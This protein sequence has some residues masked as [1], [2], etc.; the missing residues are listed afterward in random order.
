MVALAERAIAYTKPYTADF[1]NS[2]VVLKEASDDLW[3]AFETR[4]L[5]PPPRHLLPVARGPARARAHQ[6]AEC[7]RVHGV[8]Q[9]RSRL[10]ATRMSWR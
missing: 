10:L 6:G 1:V 8:D 4:I 7:H 9:V 3:S 2:R 5:A